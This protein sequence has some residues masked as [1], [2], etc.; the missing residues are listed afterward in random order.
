MGFLSQRDIFAP[1][2]DPAGLED[3]ASSLFEEAAAIHLTVK[4]E[5]F[6]RSFAHKA[7]KH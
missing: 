6:F 3:M 1:F 7:K 4:Q 2:Y 5:A